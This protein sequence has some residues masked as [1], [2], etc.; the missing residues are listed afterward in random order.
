M[1]LD[2]EGAL[3]LTWFGRAVQ[4][5]TGKRRERSSAVCAGHFARSWLTGWAARGSQEG[6]SMQPHEQ[7]RRTGTSR[8][9]LHAPGPLG[10]CATPR[11]RARMVD[12]L[13]RRYRS[14][15]HRATAQSVDAR[16][17]GADMVSVL[18]RIPGTGQRVLGAARHVA[19]YVRWQAGVSRPRKGGVVAR[20]R[21]LAPPP[22]A[23][24]TSI[25]DSRRRSAS[26]ASSP[27][28]DRPQPA[29]KRRPRA[30]PREDIH[31]QS[32]RHPG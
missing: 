3:P 13:A 17:R 16:K 22:A 27:A 20:D 10:A 12:R 24:G 23:A 19:W 15:R 1:V 11:R 18:R 26:P 29:G 32:A 8:Q 30:R 31:E 28:P 6:G 14:A 5:R 25:W 9:R 21:A 4:Y 2:R 7:T